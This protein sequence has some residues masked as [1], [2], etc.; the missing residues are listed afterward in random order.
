MEQTHV[1]DVY[2]IIADEFNDSRYSVW[3]FVKKFL[4]NKESLYGIDIGCGNGKNMIHTNMIGID[5]CDKFVNICQQ[6][7]KNCVVSNCLN[8]PFENDSF[9]YAIGISVFHHLSTHERRV[10]AIK[11][12]IRVVKDGGEMIFNIWSEEDQPKRKFCKGD[13]FVSWQTRAKK[14]ISPKTYE[15]YYYICDKD[16]FLSLIADLHISNYQIFNECGNW[17][18]KIIIHKSNSK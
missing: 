4:E 11:E 5:A 13:N 3:N 14:N 18:V 2:D 8:L 16:L 17:I 7:G 15:R 1:H 6:K 12:M 9:D 10:Q